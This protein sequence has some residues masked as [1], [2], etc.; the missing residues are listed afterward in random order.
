MGT[1]LSLVVKA[2]IVEQIVEHRMQVT[3]QAIHQWLI[4]LVHL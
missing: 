4:P 3:V 2:V 1:T